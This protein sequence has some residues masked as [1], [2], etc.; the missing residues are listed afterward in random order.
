MMHRGGLLPIKGIQ[1]AGTL[2]EYDEVALEHS[3]YATI[4][5]ACFSD[6]RRTTSTSRLECRRRL[7]A[8]FVSAHHLGNRTHSVE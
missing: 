2:L 3:R 4:A 6:T 5:L 7:V 1:R 8:V